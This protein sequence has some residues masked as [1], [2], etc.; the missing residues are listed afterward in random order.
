MFDRKTLL[1]VITLIV[2]FCSICYELLLAQALSLFLSN[3]V[4]RYSITIGLY[5]FAM[6]LGARTV[7]GQ[8]LESP[9]RQ[10]LLVEIYLTG[11]G[12]FLLLWLYVLDSILGVGLLFGLIAHGLILLIG[13]L[14]GKELPILIELMKSED[15]QA[16][17]KVLAYSYFGAVIG[18]FVFA[19]VYYPA[20]GLIL[21]AVVTGL[22]N[23][24]AGLLTNYLDTEG[25]QEKAV[26]YYSLA[27]VQVALFVT[28][29]LCV[30]FAPT[31]QDFLAG[32]YIK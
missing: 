7:E 19:F 26:R 13:F 21:A 24:I 32:M 17:S 12:G 4:L 3:T 6:G 14:T 16:E 11:I 25:G 10:L 23:S 8:V 9:R 18:T 20:V 2:S 31:W 22:L 15:D 28:M 27:Y 1:I 29:A 30:M 5:L